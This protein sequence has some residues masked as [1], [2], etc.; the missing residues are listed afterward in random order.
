MELAMNVTAYL[1]TTYQSLFLQ[2]PAYALPSSTY[3]HWRVHADHVALFYEK[4]PCLVAE[5]AH[6]NLWYGSTC[7]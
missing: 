1:S 2:Y 3:R 7:S 4:L 6:L 5:F